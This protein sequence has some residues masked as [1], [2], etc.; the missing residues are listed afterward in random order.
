M[1][2]ESTFLQYSGFQIAS[3]IKSGQIA[4]EI[5]RTL[6]ELILIHE[7]ILTLNDAEI[8]IHIRES[9]NGSFIVLG[10]AREEAV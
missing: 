4:A 1:T 2:G 10:H 3:A 6:P 9:S 7:N 5:D 8:S